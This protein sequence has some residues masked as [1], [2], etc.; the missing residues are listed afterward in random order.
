MLTVIYG[1]NNSGK[2][3]YA[4]D[5]I[6]KYDGNL[7]YVATMVAVNEDNEKRIAKHQK[8]RARYNFTTIEEPTDLGNVEV[9]ETDNVLLE[10][11]Q[12]L[13]ANHSIYTKAGTKYR[14]SDLCDQLFADI[15]ALNERCAN[16]VVVTLKDLGEDYLD[17]DAEKF[18]Y[19]LKQLNN[20]LYDACD[21]AYDMLAGRP[22]PF[23]TDGKDVS[24]A[25]RKGKGL[26]SFFKKKKSV[27][28]DAETRPEIEAETKSAESDS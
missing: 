8:R 2:S 18:D 27:D 6:T 12:N 14:Y 28:S 7:V 13:L 17:E 20:Q 4:E 25:S 9:S 23:K 16:L 22:V 15:M 1:E 21:A 3:R 26:F 10:D 5:L 11:V 24:R 19:A